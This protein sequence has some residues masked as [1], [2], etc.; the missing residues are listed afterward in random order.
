[1]SKTIDERVVEM[2]FDNKQFESNVQT[3]LS[4]LSKLKQSLNLTGAAKGLE[5]VNS[6]A[7]EVNLSGLSG[8]VE[9]VHAKFSAFEVMA[10]TALMNITNSAVDAGK[11]LV[12]SLS[13][14]QI[15]AG[16]EKYADKTSA[17]QTIMAA[18]AKDFTDTGKQMDYVNSQLDKLN[19]F[20]DE[21]SY[22]F[23]DMVSNIGKFTS[24]SVKL[25][26]AVT[27]MQGISTWAAIS[28]ANTQEASRAMYNLSQAIAVGS[29]K[30]IDWK[31]IENANMA[32]TEFKQTVIDTAVALGTLVD[33][34]NGLYETLEGNEVSVANFNEN[35]KDAWFTSEVLLSSLDRYGGFSDKLY[36]VSQQTKMTATELLEAVSNYKEGTLDISKLSNQTG[37]SVSQLSGIFDELSSETMELGQR[38]FRAAQE[39]KT[40]KEA[41]DSVK[42]AVS[43][44]W[45][46]TF[47][48]IFG[49]Y[50]EAKKL[51]T[52]VA[53][54][55]YDIFAS[56][57]E[58]RNEMLGEWKDLGGRQAM[59]QAF[60]NIWESL[61]AVL[62]TVKSAFHDIFPSMTAERLV[63]ITENVRDLTE[64]FKM[65][66]S[67]STNLKNTFRGLFAVLDIVKQAISAVLRVV[68]P[69]VGQFGGLS[70]KLLGVTGSFGEWLV[71]I[72]E[73]IKKND[74]FNKSIQALINFVKNAISSFKDF[75][76]NIREKLHL[77]DIDA[78]KESL[79]KFIK[80][81]G[82]K[83]K[84]PGLELVNSI[85]GK[86]SNRMSQIGKAAEGMKTVSI[87]AIDA[88][89]Q[90]M[91]NCK[92]LQILEAIWKAIKTITKG[93]AKA[94]GTLMGN[95]AEKIGN[96][97]FDGILD[98]INGLSISG[99]AL[100]ISKF[101]KS[102][103]EP[104]E[105]LQGIIKG[106]TGILDSVRGC[107][108]A[109]QTQLKAGA[110]LKIATAIGILTA[111]ILTLSLIDSEKLNS[112]LGAITVMF[113]DL[114]TSMA[115]FS[116]ISGNMRGVTKSSAAMLAM[117]T[118]VLILASALKKISAL[119]PNELATGMIGVVGLTGTIV[120][121]TKIMSAGERNVIKGAGSIVIFSAAIK[122]LASVCKDLS[123]LD[124]KELAKGLV[125]VGALLTEVSIFLR[126]AKFSGKTITTSAGIVILSSAIKILASACKDFARM[127]WEEIG[128]GLAGVSALLLEIA[129]F[130]KLTN[131][132]KHVI[133]S[134][135]ALIALG[136]AMKIFAS[137]LKDI[138]NMSWEELARGLS[139]MAGAL[140]AVTAALNF[141]PKNMVGIGVGLTAV[142]TALIIMAEVLQRMGGMSWEEIAKGL[143]A[144]AGS[145]TILAVG[146]K[147]MTGTLSGSAS[148]LVAATSLAILT[149]VLKALGGMS[150]EEIAKGLVT[151]A[152]AFTII[153]VAGL[154]L[155]PIIPNILALGASFALIGVGILGIGAG[156]LAA[157]V[158]LQALSVG[159]A[160]FGT[161]LAAG[162]AA[163]AAGLT[164]ILVGIAD[165]IPVVIGKIGEG[166]IEICKT[167][168]A[169]MPE[170]GEAVKAIVLTIM[171]VLVECLPVIV[172]GVLVL[173]V[174]I[175]DS[176]VKYTPKIVDDIFQFLIKVLDGIAKNLPALIQ[177]A[178]KVIMAFFA[179]VADALSNIDTD[180]L[181]K[182]IVGIGLL[183]AIML[184][185][186]AVSSLVPG[187]M[188][189]VF[190]M[191]AVLAEL[192]LVLA[193]IG[194]LEQI[195]GLNWLIGEGGKLLEGIGTAI[196][197]F[198]GGIVGGFMS[199]VSSQFPR[200]GSDLSAFMKNVQ[201]FIEGASKINADAMNGVKS[202]AEVILL[203]TAA[204]I[205]NGLASWLTGGTSIVDFGKELAEFGPHFNSYYKS[206]KGIDG[207][208][209]Q[210]SANAAKALAEMANNLPK[211][212]G[213]VGWFEGE[214]S[215]S[216][217]AD[218]LMDFGPSLKSYSDSI[219]GL[220]SAVVVE[221]ANAAKAISEMANN[222]P[223][224]GGVVGW[225]EGENSL[226]DFAKELAEFGPSLKLYSD[227]VKGVDGE[228]VVN[229]ANAAKA[230]SEMANNLPS[231]GGVVSWFTGDNTLSVFGEELAAF[232]PK[233]KKY[234]DSTKGLDAN[235]VVNSANAAK[236]LAELANNLP[237]Q[238]GIASWFVG[239]KNLGTFGE[240]LVVFGE[241][242][243][244]YSDYMKN[245]NANI[246]T[247]TTNAANSIVE[248][249][250]NLPED[251]GWFSN[252]KTLG[253]FGSDIAA[254][255]LYF[256]G[257]YNHIST[258]NTTQLSHVIT[259][260][261]N[262]VSMARGMNNLDTSGMENFGSALNTLAQIGIND[263]INA[264]TNS[265]SRIK[266]TASKM[267]NTF[268]SSVN[269]KKTDVKAAFIDLLKDIVTSMNSKVTSFTESGKMLVYGFIGGIL[270]QGDDTSTA[271]IQILQGTI[272]KVNAQE[273]VF[274]DSARALMNHFV[275][276]ITNKKPS[277]QNEIISVVN[278][279]ISSIKSKYNDFY[280]AGSYLIEGFIS[281]INS[282][283][284]NVNTAANAMANAAVNAVKVTLDEHSPSKVGYELGDFFGIAF[285][286]AI[287]DYE[288]KSYEAGRDVAYSAKNGLGSAITKISDIID[289]DIDI[290]P[291]IRPVVD[292]SG[293][294]R[295]AD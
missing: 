218:E 22:N 90:A 192:S 227:S 77:P 143:V 13:V 53:N 11:R 2:R 223:K 229:S 228:V 66:D 20:T 51:W 196:G 177:A 257:Y 215:L 202:L 25:D 106:V 224:H 247:T 220:D 129:A 16:W 261:N 252:T 82:E 52:N 35:L 187:A 169:G 19:W 191:G 256:S 144:L 162:S 100:A 15:T 251:G 203:L 148:I 37:L 239:D 104:L 161:S 183:S 287:K 80:I 128:K 137:A 131:N 248:L 103:S 242:F 190:G 219:K 182:G 24:N 237:N 263:F 186:S 167:I 174:D 23:L 211:H 64:K 207:S 240:G 45:M 166:I 180:V 55:L 61:K 278:S 93:I 83:I 12:S 54:E 155:G 158:G 293:V 259:E 65:N 230:I 133:S 198:I 273:Q 279:T 63:R 216:D 209:I 201:P 175:L 47:E 142:S 200:I 56:S 283:I 168:T 195:P 199:G 99:I 85:L 208:V 212:G 72:D 132:A 214:N 26:T 294:S 157:G 221:S 266:E 134:G 150:W 189:G 33:K 91:V 116:K 236:S 154:V 110:L 41:L 282:N 21:T 284:T 111:S 210:S 139:G 159:I 262:L 206:V 181:L 264:F 119:K 245:V 49:N 138:S 18:T 108:E 117:S 269:S 74:T 98:I 76:E 14:D 147:L 44:G 101:L 59:L 267:L 275:S 185:L 288:N 60:V 96:T 176:L 246:V 250:K 84:T 152:G 295:S 290:Q 286:N 34:G 260:T 217:F 81:V 125:G 114:M 241:Q 243:S 78:I 173:I 146:L 126:T 30:L 151:I 8:A 5:N 265:K 10:I 281:G 29:V 70:N 95:I 231:Q 102:V 172:D 276:G 67:T 62:D 105:G 79:V 73:F 28:G 7:K 268:I 118:S 292:L 277:V 274:A 254:F 253:D 112:S 255:G 88:M 39:A 38:S 136:T 48:L 69:L 97:D 204:D 31:S 238:G 46:N 194:L 123:Q 291:T 40:F 3:S 270:S 50:E 86:I 213:V 163:I 115:I 122:I 141:M 222:L 188:V 4:T 120:A 272:S 193:A 57:S 92:F 68:S 205:L 130:T 225:F 32:T 233:L 27:A 235:V 171:D 43:T 17:V 178:M 165:M 244:K 249:Q 121:A 94:L 107:F 9:T 36:E 285:V 127:S 6:A 135:I 113:A 109:Y 71:K 232:G 226:S 197:N 280:T 170:I 179:G 87:K 184:A 289:S 1:M 258:I 58:A 145:I 156:L 140:L 234:S 149:P 75:A 164:V 124:W 153:G 42:D 271:M 89:G 160:A